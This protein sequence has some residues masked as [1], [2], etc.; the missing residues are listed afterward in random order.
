MKFR[1]LAIRLLG[2]T[3]AIEKAA[4][5]LVVSQP[6]MKVVKDLPMW[7]QNH[8]VAGGLTPEQVSA[9]FREADNGNIARQCD[10]ANSFRQK[11]GHLQ[12]IL[13]RMELSVAGLPW[14]IVPPKK[15]TQKE[16]KACEQVRDWLETLPMAQLIAHHV[17]ANYYGHAV[18]EPIYEKRGGKFVP[19]GFDFLQARRFGYRLTDGAFVFL[20][21]EMTGGTD[22]GIRLCEEFPGKFIES[23]PRVTGDVG[24]REGLVRVLMWA[25]LFRNWTTSDWLRLAEMAW[26]PW[27]IAKHS[28]EANQ[29]TIDSLV[30]VLTDMATSGVLVVRDDC[31]FELKFPENSSANPQN[32]HASLFETLGREMSKAVLSAT[33]T[34]ESSKS[35]GYAQGKVHETGEDKLTEYRA[36]CVADDVSNGL[37]TPCFAM[38]FA[39]C[40]PG[41]IAVI[42]KDTQD[43]KT[44]SIGV[45]TLKEA[46]VAIP[47]AWVRDEAGIPEP[48][49]GE[50]VIGG[51]DDPTNETPDEEDPAEKP[52]ADDVDKAA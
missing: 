36:K 28:V 45:K 16:L 51:P 8:R 31:E 6:T 39:G 25:A 3:P 52:E 23:H 35:S 22:Q 1:D 26:K 30:A 32:N 37:V 38:N 18:T 33:E 11:D 2:F 43:L 9:I 42:T 49:D 13:S 46:G 15:P 44:F 7:R 17:G 19:V 34:T 20:P 5:D 14:A 50:E 10:L 47:V 4:S 40:R 29:E 12:S 24:P 41:R 27:R 48:V 21:N